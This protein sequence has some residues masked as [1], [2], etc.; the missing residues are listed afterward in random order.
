M[1]RRLLLGFD[2]YGQDPLKLKVL[3]EL[4]NI[5]SFD[6]VTLTNTY[7]GN[8]QLLAA[9]RYGDPE[10]YIILLAYNG[11]GNS[12]AFTEGLSIRIPNPSE[13]RMVLDKQRV[14]SSNAR[15]TSTNR[16]VTI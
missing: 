6:Q 7:D 4:L 2:E 3:D 10:F 11:I 13:V 8:P 9:E 14:A 5:R 16:T 12:F 15:R 1:S